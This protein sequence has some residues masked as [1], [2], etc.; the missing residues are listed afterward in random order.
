MSIS[1]PKQHPFIALCKQ[2][3]SVRLRLAVLF[4]LFFIVDIEFYGI[5]FGL[6]HLRGNKY[7]NGILV[8]CSD[9][10]S[11]TLLGLVADKFGRKKAMLICSATLAVSALV[12]DLVSSYEILSYGLIVITRM[13]AAS[14]F[15]LMFLLAQESYPTEVRG[16]VFGIANAFARVGGAVAP[17]ASTIPHFMIILSALG[18]IAFLL[19]LIMK[20]TKGEKMEDYVIVAQS[21]PGAKEIE[22]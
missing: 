4:I 9:I 6:D 21:E 22:S 18:A 8:G 20:E 3:N 10:V 5:S 19:T 11:C 1:K 17:L 13:G 7:A 15:A 12:Y 14:S 16:T 2:G